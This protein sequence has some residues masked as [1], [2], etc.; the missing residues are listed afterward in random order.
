MDGHKTILSQVFPLANN[1]RTNV[2]DAASIDKNVTAR[3]SLAD[4]HFAL[5]KFNHGTIFDDR[6]SLPS[7]PQIARHRSVLLEVA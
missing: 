2:T 3:K 5:G 7:H 1:S 4:S 6:D